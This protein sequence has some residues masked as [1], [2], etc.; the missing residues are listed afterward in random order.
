[1]VKGGVHSFG[2]VIREVSGVAK[3]GFWLRLINKPNKWAFDSKS[4]NQFEAATHAVESNK[5]L[6]YQHLL[7]SQKALHVAGKC[8]GAHIQTQAS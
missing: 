3:K 8:K 6:V 1:M 2:C 4:E 7:Y 5:G